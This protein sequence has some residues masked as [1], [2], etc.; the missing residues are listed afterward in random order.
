MKNKNEEIT[1][2][3]LIL[4]LYNQFLSYSLLLTSYYRLPTT[5]YRL[6]PASAHKYHD[7]VYQRSQ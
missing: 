6:S 3:L 5:N 1:S 7:I 4:K 2:Y